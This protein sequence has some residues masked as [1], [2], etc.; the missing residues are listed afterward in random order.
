MGMK[1]DIQAVAANGPSPVKN[2]NR[3]AAAVAGHE[4]LRAEC[5]SAV[6]RDKCVARAYLVTVCRL[7]IRVL[8]A[9]F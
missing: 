7:T 4:H 3:L 8:A 5:V 9:A 6:G 1:E 2:L